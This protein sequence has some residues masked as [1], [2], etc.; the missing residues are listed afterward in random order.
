MKFHNE[1]N[2]TKTSQN[3]EKVALRHE[4]NGVSTWITNVPKFRESLDVKDRQEPTK[5]YAELLKQKRLDDKLA[6]YL[7]GQFRPYNSKVFTK[8]ENAEEVAKEYKAINWSP[9]TFQYKIVQLPNG[10]Y[11]IQ[12]RHVGSDS[13]M[14]EALHKL[15]MKA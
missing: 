3:R 4:A 9:E 5:R 14:Q 8:S 12:F 1:T 11:Q 15:R 2:P 13:E 7:D 10:N 6:P